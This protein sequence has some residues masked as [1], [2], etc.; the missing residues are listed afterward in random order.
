[1]L[2][3]AL[4]HEGFFSVNSAMARSDR[5]LSLM[6]RV[7]RERVLLE[8]EGSFVETDGRPASPFDLGTAVFRYRSALE[9][10]GRRCTAAAV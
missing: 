2:E 1:M 9:H 3:R 6:A 4:G 5:P 7:P 10:H 8:S